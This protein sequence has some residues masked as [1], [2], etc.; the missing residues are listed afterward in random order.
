M[1]GISPCFLS[2]MLYNSTNLYNLTQEA[3]M[4]F[5]NRGIFSQRVDSGVG[6]IINMSVTWTRINS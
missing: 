1:Y 4:N 6:E 2:K 3:I 5:P